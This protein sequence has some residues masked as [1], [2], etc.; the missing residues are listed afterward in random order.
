MHLFEKALS[1]QLACIPNHIDTGRTY[2]N[3]GTLFAD[4]FDNV[5]N[6]LSNFEQALKIYENAI[7]PSGD[8]PD[9][10]YIRDDFH[11]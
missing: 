4:E 9:L 2:F 7:I 8:H 11:D 6:A 3:I 10:I 5:P 1:I